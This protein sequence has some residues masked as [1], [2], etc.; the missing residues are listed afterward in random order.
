LRGENVKTPSWLARLQK[1]AGCGVTGGAQQVWGVE[2]D[3]N[4]K[5]DLGVGVLGWIACPRAVWFLRDEEEP[6]GAPYS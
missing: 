2:F 5:Q 6:A 1:H 3:A 4:A